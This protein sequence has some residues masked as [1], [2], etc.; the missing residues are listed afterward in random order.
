MLT[1]FQ[2]LIDQ[3]SSFLDAA[4]PETV[5]IAGF[6]VPLPANVAPTYRRRVWHENNYRVQVR[7]T[8][9][10]RRAK[11]AELAPGVEDPDSDTELVVRGK[12]YRVDF[13]TGDANTLRIEFAYF[14]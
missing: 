13:T 6:P 9:E 7:G 12:T 3:A 14:S 5:T 1:G 2:A 11:L 8:L 10:I 4:D